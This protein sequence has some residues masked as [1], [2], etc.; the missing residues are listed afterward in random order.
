MS[1]SKNIECVEIFEVE[2]HGGLSS[3]P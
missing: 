3:S 2:G 1:F